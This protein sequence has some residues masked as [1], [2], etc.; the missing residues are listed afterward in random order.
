MSMIANV[1]IYFLAFCKSR[2]NFQKIFLCVIFFS[3]M[4]IFFVG[5][6][7]YKNLEKFHRLNALHFKALQNISFL[8]RELH[9]VQREIF[10]IKK[11]K[12]SMVLVPGDLITTISSLNMLAVRSKLKIEKLEPQ[13][14]EELGEI[15]S[16][17]V[18]TIEVLGEYAQFLEYLNHILQKHHLLELQA[19][20][21]H[22]TL[23]EIISKKSF[24]HS[25]SPSLRFYVQWILHHSKNLKKISGIASLT[26]E[27]I[28]E[29]LR[30]LKPTIQKN[31][32]RGTTSE[33]VPSPAVT[34]IRTGQF[35][36]EDL[37]LL[38]TLNSLD[39]QSAL[40]LTPNN[41]PLIA[42]VGD[43]F[44]DRETHLKKIGVGFVETETLDQDEDGMRHHSV[45]LSVVPDAKMSFVPPEHEEGFRG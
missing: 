17:C 13:C 27:A 35:E 33:F 28:L 3:V 39:D 18:I 25:I 23:D 36:V 4:L 22:S 6:S 24:D 12:K 45:K 14:A 34:P 37:V 40:F 44:S 10:E 26:E 21:I 8:K 31:P 2:I 29:N 20:K 16:P 15:G 32:F 9:A 5:N 11:I 30:S 41:Q 19:L 1:K 38:G 42:R 7:F 43:F